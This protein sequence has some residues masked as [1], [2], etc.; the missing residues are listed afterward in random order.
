MFERLPTRTRTAL[1][2]GLTAL[3]VFSGG[4]W[5]LLQHLYD[6]RYADTQDKARVQARAVARNIIINQHASGL[7][8]DQQNW[9]FVI[10]TPQ[11][12]IAM[13]GGGAGDYEG[14]L[15]QLPMAPDDAPADWTDTNT[16]HFG[17]AEPARATAATPETHREGTRF[18]AQ[19]E[20]PS[21]NA[22]LAHRSLTAVGASILAAPGEGTPFGSLGG[23]YTVY[24]FVLPDAAQAAVD[25]LAP[26]LWTGVPAAALI[27]AATSYLSTRRALRPVEAIRTQLAEISERRLDHRVPVPR[28][29]DEISRM[30]LTTN[31]TLDRLEHAAAQ[32]QRFVADAAHELRSPLTALRTQLEI[33]LAHP[34]TT[35]WPEA[36]RQSLAATR[37]LQELADDLLFLTRPDHDQ[38]Q[39][40]L[41]DIAGLARELATEARAG[42]PH[43][44]ALTIQ[45]PPTAPV[46]GN[47]LHLTRLL[48]NLLDN[49][50]RHARTTVTVTVDSVE[51][52]GTADGMLRIRVHND[53]SPIAPADRERIF[54]R[55]T[56]L[57][58]ARSRDAGGSGLGLAIARDIAIRHNGRLYV[59]PVGTGATFTT[60]LPH[61]PPVNTPENA[62]D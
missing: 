1:L 60:E 42:H 29:R 33:S 28:A 26:Y 57:D 41:V 5:L 56:R 59:D 15:A 37:R 12:S 39:A 47:A 21:T 14:I 20:P 40:A 18:P 16:V 22:P 58:E 23:R 30:A 52:T 49:A 45:A 36:T 62:D 51:A 6:T 43:G 25:Q 4:A 54:E 61:V 3:V 31:A 44:P 2:A 32:Q 48:R 11:G 10:L 19:P 50:V 46:R 13:Q 8:T 38:R 35:D 7:F 9:P 24:V 55:F 17:A 53:G 34:H 27:V